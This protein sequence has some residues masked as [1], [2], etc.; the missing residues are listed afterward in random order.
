MDPD[1][2]MGLGRNWEVE[3]YESLITVYCMRNES[4]SNIKEELHEGTKKLKIQTGL[5]SI[6]SFIDIFRTNIDINK[7]WEALGIILG[8]RIYLGV[9]FIL[10]SND[11]VLSWQKYCNCIFN[12]S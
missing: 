9:F 4:I 1:W 12:K 10:L 6:Y 5:L 11:S 7:S 2:G 3:R 8:K